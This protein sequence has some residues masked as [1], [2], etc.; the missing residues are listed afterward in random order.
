MRRKLVVH[1]NVVVKK[2]M[3]RGSWGLCYLLKW[4]SW[5]LHPSIYFHFQGESLRLLHSFFSVINP[6]L[7]SKGVEQ[8]EKH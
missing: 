3:K 4:G 2:R 5:M 6:K 1:P 8:K 7:Q